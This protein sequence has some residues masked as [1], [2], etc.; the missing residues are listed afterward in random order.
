MGTV[1]LQLRS[2]RLINLCKNPVPKARAA[3][4]LCAYVYLTC[5]EILLLKLS[6]TASLYNSR[7]GSG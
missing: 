4:L 6:T 2:I 7:L 5:S 1:T 3:A